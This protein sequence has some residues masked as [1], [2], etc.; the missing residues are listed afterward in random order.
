MK[1]FNLFKLFVL[2]LTIATLSGCMVR[3]IGFGHYHG[4]G[5]DNG[6][7]RGHHDHDDHDRD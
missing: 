1:R 3:P 7:H 5:H 6:H 2:L 4:G